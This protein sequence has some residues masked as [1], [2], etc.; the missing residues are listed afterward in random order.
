LWNNQ[1]YSRINPLALYERYPELTFSG[2]NTTFAQTS[3]VFQTLARSRLPFRG[4]LLR[5]HFRALDAAAKER[6][7]GGQGDL[8]GEGEA[9]KDEEEEEEDEQQAGIRL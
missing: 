6:N 1:N 5:Q 3:H 4:R 7:R 2:T 9:E 8:L